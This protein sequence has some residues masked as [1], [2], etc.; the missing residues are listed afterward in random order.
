MFDRDSVAVLK[1]Y[2]NTKIPLVGIYN[3]YTDEI[4]LYPTFP[5]YLSIEMDKDGNY[6]KGEIL[7]D[8]DVLSFSDKNKKP[9][10][11]E[12]LKNYQALNYAPRTYTAPELGGWGF[13]SSHEF[14]FRAAFLKKDKE[15]K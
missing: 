12:E 6:I 4:Y 9:L 8:K 11:P 15:D 3:I 10:T 5:E 13:E 14:L 7:L 1:K 2:K